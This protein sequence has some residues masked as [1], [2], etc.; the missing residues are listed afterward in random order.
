MINSNEESAANLWE[1][2]ILAQTPD[3][4]N[5]IVKNLT[6]IGVSGYE[7]NQVSKTLR[8]YDDRFDC[9]YTILIWSC[10]FEHLYKITKIL[11]KIEKKYMFHS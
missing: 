6:I 2:E 7:V 10:C 8:N 9:K 3:M 1:L 11:K 4:L 5:D